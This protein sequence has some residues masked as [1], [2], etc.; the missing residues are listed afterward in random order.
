MITGAVPALISRHAEPA[1]TLAYP[2]DL[3]VDLPSPLITAAGTRRS[4]LMRSAPS[5]P[6]FGQ[7]NRPHPRSARYVSIA[8]GAVS[9][10]PA[11]QN[12]G[13]ARFANVEAGSLTVTE[14]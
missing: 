6:S 7:H 2:R 13:T 1:P 10:R 14:P 9:T 4:L 11:A 3:L 5:G 8:A 12:G